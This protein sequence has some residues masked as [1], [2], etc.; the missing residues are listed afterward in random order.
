MH[1]LSR[2]LAWIILLVAF[3]PVF[4]GDAPGR[5]ETVDGLRILHLTGSPRQMG[6]AHGRLLRAEARRTIRWLLEEWDSDG[7]RN[8]KEATDDALASLRRHLP[9]T[10]LD[11]LRGLAEGSGI[12]LDDLLLAHAM[13]LRIEG[14][15]GVVLRSRVVGG[16]AMH[17]HALRSPHDAD[18]KTPRPLLVVYHPSNG[19]AYVTVTWPG[20]VGAVAGMNERGISIGAQPVMTEGLDARGYP[21]S[22]RVR[23]ALRRADNLSDAVTLFRADEATEPANVLITDGK[24]PDARV[25]ERA[26]DQWAIF[27][28]GDSAEDSPPHRPLIDCLRRSNH[29]VDA[30]LSLLQRE[31]DDPR[32]SESQRRYQAMTRFVVDTETPMGVTDCLDWLRSTDQP[33]APSVVFSPSDLVFRIATDP[34]KT[35]ADGAAKP[36]RFRRF[37]LASLAAGDR[38]GGNGPAIE[39]PDRQGAVDDVPLRIGRARP[40]ERADEATIP[41]IYRLDSAPF[42]FEVEPVSLAGGVAFSKVRFPSPLETDHP[43]NNTVHAEFFR[44]FGAGPFPCVLVLHITGGDFEL[45]RFMSRALASSG[46]ASLFVK[47]PY[48]GERRPQGKKIRMVSNDLERGLASMRQVVLDL[49]RA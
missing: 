10:Y 22:L 20:Y 16:K 5:L 21:L 31:R 13:P 26:G 30:R 23:D 1:P 8:P 46:T 29:F 12:A 45:S 24:I 48:Y 28:P 40:R 7:R 33:T 34:S 9:A 47:M 11:E 43:E 42:R 44:P 27:G 18:K 38:I 2:A 3:A 25:L 19:H 35:V 6:L 41:K 37:A 49:R 17:W 32:G 4:G 39:A 15:A 14:S 36:V